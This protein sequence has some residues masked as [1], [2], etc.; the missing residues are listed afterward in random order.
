[1]DLC[2]IL[3]SLQED[4]RKDFYDIVCF[5]VERRVSDGCAIALVEV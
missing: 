1:M 5:A 3:D 4:R 2:D